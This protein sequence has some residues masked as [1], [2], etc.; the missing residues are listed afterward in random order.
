IKDGTINK[1][2]NSGFLKAD[3]P[4]SFWTDSHYTS[5]SEIEDFINQYDVSIIDHLGTDGLSHTI[6]DEVDKLS[7][8][9]FEIYCNYHYDT[10]RERTILG[11]STHGLL[12]C[13]KNEE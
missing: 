12:I 13:R 9:K 7:Q 2:I 1:V 11:I 4:E 3:D 10:C 8:D 6:S 5:P